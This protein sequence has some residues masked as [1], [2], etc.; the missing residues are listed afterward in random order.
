VADE[1]AL[2]VAGLSLAG[3]L[4]DISFEIHPGEVLGVF[5][6]LG[7]GIDQVG[8]AIYGALGAMPGARIAIGGKDYTPVNPRH[9]RDAGLG[10]VAAERQREGIVPD[11][12]VAA[13]LTLPFIDRFTRFAVVSRP[14]EL[15]YAQSWVDRLGIR[16]AYLG[17]ELRLLSGGNQQKV[18]LARWLVEGLEVLILEEPT[19]G[20][21]LGARRELYLA[22]RQWTAKG[23]AILLVSSDAEEV[24][25][26]CDRAIVL[27]RGRVSV[28]SMG[29]ARRHARRSS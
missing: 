10:F 19:R 16:S 4:D 12:G 6:L 28:W 14:R 8:R 15:D 2:Q 29:W 23:L 20:V 18:C 26:V 9:G 5:G 21:D 7:S 17:Q 24:A 1:V 22:L 27:D 11:L 3:A 13:N 25:G